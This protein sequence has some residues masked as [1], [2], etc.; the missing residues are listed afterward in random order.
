MVLV[1]ALLIT[2]AATAALLARRLPHIMMVGLAVALLATL[3]GLYLSYYVNL[4][5][6]PSIAMIASGM[7]TLTLLF[8]PGRG[9]VW[10]G[11]R[12]SVEVETA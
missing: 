8:A 7:F 6:G 11:G 10:R 1:L 5:P 12:R 3:G 9:V 4:P 2:P